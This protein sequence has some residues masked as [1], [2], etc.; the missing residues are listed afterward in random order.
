M[1]CPHCGVE[2]HWK[3]ESVKFPRESRSQV[4]VGEWSCHWTF[5]PNRKCRELIVE[6]W[7]SRK[8]GLDRHLIW[9]K[10]P[11]REPCPPEVPNEVAADYNEACAVIDISPTAAAALARHCLELVLRNNGAKGETLY[12]M[13]NDIIDNRKAPPYVTG[14]L[15]DLRQIGNTFA[16][17]AN[18]SV[19]GEV[20]RTSPEEAEWTLNTLRT[21]LK[22]YY[23]D[24]AESKARKA[25][26]AAKLAKKAK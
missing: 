1:K 14:D 3:A 25:A 21:V 4:D 8:D 24:E 18:Q 5:C 20:L 16:A 15:H 2:I 19:T 26:L 11:Y 7:D 9:P 17:H 13:I 6:L 10:H 12:N 22:H 23:V